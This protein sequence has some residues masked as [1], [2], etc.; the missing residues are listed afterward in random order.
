[1]KLSDIRLARRH[2]AFK[3][4]VVVDT[5]RG[6][7]RVRAWPKPRRA[8]NAR[9]AAIVNMNRWFKEANFLAKYVPT[10]DQVIARALAAGTPQYPRDL[11]IA[12]MAGSLVPGIDVADGTSYERTTPSPRAYPHPHPPP[13]NPPAGDPNRSPVQLPIGI[14]GDEHTNPVVDQSSFA[15]VLTTA[16][17]TGPDTSDPKQYPA[18]LFIGAT[19]SKLTAADS[20]DW[21]IAANQPFTIETFARWWGLSSLESGHCMLSKYNTTSNQRSW[22]FYHQ[23]PANNLAWIMSTN[24]L[25]PGAAGQLTCSFNPII[26]HWYHL[27]VTR[28]AANDVRLFIQGFLQG[29]KNIPGASFNSTTTLAIGGMNSPSPARYTMQG[30]L[31]GLRFT[32]GHC[33]YTTD[34]TPPTGPF[35]Q[36]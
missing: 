1:V 3:G 35:G 22:A 7:I 2:P 24:G 30:N 9:S 32:K 27:A 17:S 25:N 6:V 28:D 31:S 12:A 26:A 33:Y 14:D 21:D 10:D 23:R 16:G 18:S 29:S 15:H 4:R 5:F 36:A 13:H 20:T 11:L 34:F 8:L 19:L